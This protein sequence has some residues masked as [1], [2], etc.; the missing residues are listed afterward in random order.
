MSTQIF[1]Q[2]KIV[3]GNT[4]KPSDAEFTGRYHRDQPIYV[5]KVPVFRLVPLKDETGEVVYKHWNNGRKRVEMVPEVTG[6]EEREYV[7]EDLGNGMTPKNYAFQPTAQEVQRKKAAD[8]LTPEALLRFKRQVESVF[9][10][11]NLS[12]EDV[13]QLARDEEEMSLDELESAGG[14]PERR[15]GR[16]R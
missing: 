9:K 11:L 8:E 7:I 4:S 6:Y 1:P 10:K 12:P 15:R 2:A 16:G 5:E 13:A 3:R 14:V